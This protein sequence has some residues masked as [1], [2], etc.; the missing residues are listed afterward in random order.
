VP[1]LHFFILARRKAPLHPAE[2][3][4]RDGVTKKIN[5]KPQRPQSTVERRDHAE[6]LSLCALR[7]FALIFFRNSGNVEA[8]PA[9]FDSA[10]G[11]VELLDCD[12]LGR[13]ILE[14][15]QQF[16]DR[17]DRLIGYAVLKRL[18][19]SGSA[20]G[21]PCRQVGWTRRVI[22]PRRAPPARAVVEEKVVQR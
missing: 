10:N 19:E 8:S 7:V 22:L 6:S 4:R 1:G 18:I 9:G 12:E 17:I 11:V 2:A 20:S 3:L 13:I 15:K 14:T 5:A 16:A 21:V